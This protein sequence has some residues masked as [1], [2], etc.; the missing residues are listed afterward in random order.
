LYEL[1]RIPSPSGMEQRVTEFL[2]DTFSSLGLKTAI[3]AAGNIT[4]EAEGHCEGSRFFYV[5]HVDTV[6]PYIKPKI[7]GDYLKGRGA[8]DAKGS[9]L[10]MIDALYESRNPCIKVLGLVGEE[11]DSRGAKFLVSSGARLENVVIGEPSGNSVCIGYR[12]RVLLEISCRG[13]NRH[14]AATAR[15]GPIQAVSSVVLSIERLLDSL[16]EEKLIG[17]PTSVVSKS[18]ANV[19]PSRARLV[20]DLRFASEATLEE[21]FRGLQ[22]VLP[23]GCSYTK[24]D[25]VPPVE[26]KPSD[27]LVQALA[28]SI[29]RE[30]LRVVYIKKMGSSDMNVLRP[31]SER[32]VSFGPG[33]PKL[34]HTVNERIDINEVIAASRVL[35]NLP[36][37]FA[38]LMRAAR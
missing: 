29:A 16:G 34:S 8:V 3:D 7:V 11:R 26:V 35:R 22:A 12:G 19:V 33:D 5:S 17:A 9:L 24:R 21:F 10:A 36:E 20:Y 38:R 15:D 32:I 4:I 6:K 27:V 37:E 13:E 28:R 18:A 2:R 25:F 1:V 14:V 31:I 30:G 23:E